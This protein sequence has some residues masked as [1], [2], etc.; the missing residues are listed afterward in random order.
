MTHLVRNKIN[1]VDED[2]YSYLES[3]PELQPQI[4]TAKVNLIKSSS[5]SELEALKAKIG[6]NIKSLRELGAKGFL[7]LGYVKLKDL[8]ED[9]QNALQGLS[10][11]EITEV[12]KI[13]NSYVI[14]EMAGRIEQAG[15]VDNDLKTYIRNIIFREKYKNAIDGVLTK[16]LL[17]KH[18]LEIIRR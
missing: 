5:R 3:H 15:H 1:I 11:G 14:L 4:G 16:D 6:E 17:E 13:N 18:D 2:I 12:I 9:Y 8:R 7:D 10:Q